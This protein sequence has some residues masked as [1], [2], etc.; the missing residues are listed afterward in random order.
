[1]IDNNTKMQEFQ[2][3]YMLLDETERRKIQYEAEMNHWIQTCANLE[4]V[5]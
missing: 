5:I 4:K 1:M 2:N 3:R